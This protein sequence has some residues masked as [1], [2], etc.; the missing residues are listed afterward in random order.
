[1][2][3]DWVSVAMM[4]FTPRESKIALNTPVPT[5]TSWATEWFSKARGKGAVFTKFKYSPRT[6]E[7]TP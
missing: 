3:R 5:P 2:A 1:M 4:R 7:N 6:G